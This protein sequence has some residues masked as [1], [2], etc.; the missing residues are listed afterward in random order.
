MLVRKSSTWM[1]AF[2][3]FCIVTF[4]PSLS[5]AQA[6]P[7]PEQLQQM[8]VFLNLMQNFF[9][10]IESTYELAADPEKAAIL[11]MHKIQEVYEER[12]EKPKAVDVFRKVIADSSNTTIR[13]A[14]YFMLGDALK[15]TG[16]HREAIEVL[17]QALAENIGRAK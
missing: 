11:Q 1:Q 5:F 3:L 2:A 16:N 9:K 6:A 12:G 7:G 4:S 17:S 8:Q 14:A 13:N 10:I 15:E